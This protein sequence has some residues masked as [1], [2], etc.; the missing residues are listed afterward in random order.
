MRNLTRA[1][2]KYVNAGTPLVLMGL[3]WLLLWLFPWRPAYIAEPHWGHNDAQSLAF[4]CVRLAYFSR[5]FI[6]EVLALIASLQVIPAALELLPHPVTGIAG[7]VLAGLIIVDIVIERGRKDDPAAPANRRLAFW[8]KRH[9]TRFSLIM[10]SHI[11]LI[12]FF[13]RLPAGPYEQAIVTMVFDGMLVV[14]V[15]L[16]LMEGAVQVLGRVPLTR[17]CFLWGMLTI[18]VALIILSNQ[19]E[20]WPYLGVSLLVTAGAIYALLAAR[21][22]VAAGVS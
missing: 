11:S 1:L 10:L 14:Y 20:T 3:M 4:L 16:A 9:T 19:P 8:L 2:V 15:L 5:R 22:V 17:L 21:P 6:S 7:G 13:V 18:I 12:Y